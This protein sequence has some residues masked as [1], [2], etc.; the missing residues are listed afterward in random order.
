MRLEQDKWK[1]T[2][3]KNK[4]INPTK[5][6]LSLVDLPSSFRR[7]RIYSEFRYQDRQR[8][9]H[10]ECECESYV[11][12]RARVLE[13]TRGHEER[14]DLAT[15]NIFG[16]WIL[17]RRRSAA[18]SSSSSPIAHSIAYMCVFINQRFFFLIISNCFIAPFL[19]RSQRISNHEYVP[20]ISCR[21]RVQTGC[22][23]KSRSV[24]NARVICTYLSRG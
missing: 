16:E 8:I 1:S 5:T 19:R 7:D 12:K 22:T 13:G 23:V 24:L 21:L 10:R 9:S 20:T 14:N 3:V 18:G 4:R 6:Y 15:K 11:Q 2:F 17:T